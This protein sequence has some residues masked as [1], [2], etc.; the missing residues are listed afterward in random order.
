MYQYGYMYENVSSN[1]IKGLAQFN[2]YTEGYAVYA[3]YEALDYLTNID[4]NLLTLYAEN[5]S[6]HLIV[7]LWQ[8]ILEFIMKVITLEQFTDYMSQSGFALDED[9]AKALYAQLQANPAVF[10]PYY[11]G[12]EV[13][14]D[15]KKV[16][17]KN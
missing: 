10:E 6:R 8:Q 2:A 11:V 9:S 4:P 13:I 3:Q 16:P 14:Q 7:L 15:L 1:L 12:N 17:R 5:S